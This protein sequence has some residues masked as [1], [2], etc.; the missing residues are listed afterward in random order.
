MNVIKPR[1]LG[2]L[3]KVYPDRPALYLSLGVLGYFDFATPGAFLPDTAMWPFVQSVLPENTPLDL[4]MPKVCGEVLVLGKAMAPQGI[5]VAAMPVEFAIGAIRKRANVFGDRYWK[6]G[7]TGLHPTEPN[8]FTEMPV[9]YAHAFGGAGYA[10]NP[11]GKGFD[12]ERRTRAGEAVGLPNVEA[13]ERPVVTPGDR[14]EPYGFGP[15][16][17]G[18]A[19]RT[20]KAGTFDDAWFKTRAPSAPLDQDPTIYNAAPPDQW[21]R[22]GWFALDE[23]FALAGFHA[24][25][26]ID[27]GRLPGMRARAFIQQKQPDGGTA[28]LEIG[29]HLE[30][31]FLFATARKGVVLYRGRVPV[32]NIDGRDVT[33]VMIAYERMADAPRPH[34]HY[35]EV[36]K[37]RTD[38]E[39]KGL[40]AMNEL[41]LAPALPPELVAER[42]A[43]REAFA[44]AQ[45]EK[46]QRRLDRAYDAA[47]AAG[48][49][50]LKPDAP[51]PKATP[52]AFPT[53][54]PQDI[55][56]GEVDIAGFVAAGRRELGIAQQHA[57]ESRARGLAVQSEARAKQ[58]ARAAVAP[59]A[60]P[61]PD[62]SLKPLHDLHARLSAVKGPDMST[63]L[64]KLE[65]A[66]APR[67]TGIGPEAAAL[68]RSVQDEAAELEGPVEGAEA[69]AK[70]NLAQT[71]DD[72][73]RRLLDAPQ[74]DSAQMKGA[75]RTVEAALRPPPPPASGGAAL[76]AVAPDPAE[77]AAAATRAALA[78][79]VAAAPPTARGDLLAKAE[80]TEAAFAKAAGSRAAPAAALPAV[81]F[82]SGLFEKLPT[83]EA[84]PQK[85]PLTDEEKAALKAKLAAV[86]DEGERKSRL[87]NPTA[88]APTEP[89]DAE[90]AGR[91]RR[92]VAEAAARGSPLSG[93][94]LAGVDLSGLNFRGLDL[95]GALFEKANLTGADFSGAHLARAVFTE[96]TLAGARFDQ[97]DL[98]DTNFCGVS[99][100]GASLVG[101]DLTE[102]RLFYANFDGADLT[103]ARF[104]RSI[105]LEGHFKNAVLRQTQWQKCSLITSELAGADLSGARMT[106]CNFMKCDL[107]NAR[108]VGATLF[109]VAVTSCPADGA[110]FS[111]AHL[112]RM[113]ASGGSSFVGG[114]FRR[115]FAGRSNWYKVD[116]S[117]ADFTRAELDRAFI[118]EAKA[119]EACF[120]RASLQQAFLGGTDFTDADFSEANLFR[121][122]LRHA[123]LDRA[124]LR[125]ASLYCAA[126]DGASWQLADLTKAN[127]RLTVFAR[128]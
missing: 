39:T 32:Q 103:G 123:V 8:P 56:R 86:R 76:G 108:F 119:V 62:V 101:V 75:L 69:K 122:N 15:L 70:A 117:R 125:H 44:T 21:R 73:R 47:L 17:I 50:R 23:P 64:S 97:A 100:A 27:R 80:T 92:A 66:I 7:V 68:R 19:D 87:H 79:A 114:T 43:E 106:L 94:D 110:D 1:G 16:D 26:T 28:L 51:R 63:A 107:T 10:R 116:L 37:L 78:R 29:L 102:A 30:T 42:E 22:D 60:A 46:R 82:S 128:G 54:T 58:A 36:F 71:L 74:Q 40:H 49:L 72:V 95:T 83:D 4:A 104:E 90:T 31:V 67:K 77:Q 18:W 41:Q 61:P 113:I 121:A 91:L 89:L 38:P 13:P 98:R 127:L 109:R 3:T 14:P 34:E 81:T 25:H 126:T 6:L 111:E 85:S 57:A 33:D 52:S 112:A 48:G 12:A 2:I 120:Y 11:A 124:E 99:A 20:G 55:A 96:A 88:M 5:P 118:G 9:D 53:I 59:V 45:L 105:I 24:E 115:A 84:S 65:G 35:I 93:C